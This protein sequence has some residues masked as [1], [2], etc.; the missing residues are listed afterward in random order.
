MLNKCVLNPCLMK[1]VYNKFLAI[2]KKGSWSLEFFA[3]ETPIQKLC[4]TNSTFYEFLVISNQILVFSSNIIIDIVSC[5]IFMNQKFCFQL[6][7]HCNFQ[8]FY[9]LSRPKFELKTFIATSFQLLNYKKWRILKG[10]E[11]LTEK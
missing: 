8:Y 2:S 7:N 10:R 4:L 6:S 3:K 11:T 1:M 9:T 5:V